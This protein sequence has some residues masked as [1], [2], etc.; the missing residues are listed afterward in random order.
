MSTASEIER[1]P[2]SCTR[3]ASQ[4]GLGR[5]GSTPVTVRATNSGQAAD[6]QHDRV[7]VG[8]RQ[9]DRSVDRVAERHARGLGRLPGQPADGQAVAAVGGDRD[10]QHLVAQPQHR[11][12]V[13]PRRQ[14]RLGQHHDPG[15]VVAQPELAG[16][17]IIPSETW[18]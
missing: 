6:C 8:H 9:R 1:M 10:V 15:V 17:Q 4:R 18:P 12:G 5:D 11:R 14:V 16:E 13:L 7:A 3:R 2:A